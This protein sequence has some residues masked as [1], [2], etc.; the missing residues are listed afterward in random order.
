MVSFGSTGANH[1]LL[2]YCPVTDSG[3]PKKKRQAVRVF[4]LLTQ[5]T[6][7]PR[8]TDNTGPPLDTGPAQ[9]GLRLFLYD[10]CA[11]MR[12]LGFQGKNEARGVIL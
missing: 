1:S 6:K 7:A 9:F 11:N 5:T 10:P 12:T 4:L 3:L 8:R 2:N